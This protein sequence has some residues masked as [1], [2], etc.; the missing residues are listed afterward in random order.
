MRLPL[1]SY[2][3]MGFFQEKK[4]TKKLIFSAW[5]EDFPL[6]NHSGV[7]FI[8]YQFH[9]DVFV[10]VHCILLMVITPKIKWSI[11][12]HVAYV[13]VYFCVFL[14]KSMSWKPWCLLRLPRWLVNMQS[15]GALGEPH[16]ATSWVATQNNEN[17]VSVLFLQCFQSSRRLHTSM[18][19]IGFVIGYRVSV[20]VSPSLFS[21]ELP[22]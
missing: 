4:K 18:A 7:V 20:S 9:W 12:F 22:S 13:S 6:L 15:R 19:L 14:R 10:G 1:F 16:V 8:R 17:Y 21:R 2:D 5:S 11:D 3:V